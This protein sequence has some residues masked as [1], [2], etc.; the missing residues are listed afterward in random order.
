MQTPAQSASLEPIIVVD[1]VSAGYDDEMVYHDVSFSVQRGEIIFIAG[2]S[3][4]GK[5]TLLRQMIGLQPVAAGSIRILKHR[6]TPDEPP[7]PAMTRDFGVAFQGGALFGSRTVLENVT[8]P[9]EQFTH[10]PPHLIQFTAMTKLHL[11]G[12]ENAAHK[13]PSELSGGMQKRAA[14]ARALALDPQIVFLDEPSA[15]LD[16]L[17]S[18]GL[19]KLIAELNQVLGITFVIVSHELASID[20]IAQRVAVL[21]NTARTLVALDSPQAL[22]SRCSDPWV[23]AFFSRDDAAAAVAPVHEGASP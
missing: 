7:D 15:G 17:I 12:L 22:R 2:N 4:G 1:S 9:L 20:A 18:S 10:L 6:I 21:R 8:L 19:D 3:G 11:V 14:L 23:R 13:L 16:P 5:S